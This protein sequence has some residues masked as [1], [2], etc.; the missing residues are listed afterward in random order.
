MHNAQKPTLDDLPSARQLWRS[1][2][3]AAAAAAAILVTVV[4]PS[5]YAIDP[6]GIGGVLGLTEMGEIKAQLAEEA[7]A[8]RLMMEGSSEPQSSVQPGIL[9]A[10]FGV[11]VGTAHAQEAPAATPAWREEITFTLTPG[12]GIEIKLVMS[13]GA[14][15]P[16]EW[17]VEGGAVNFDLHGDGSGNNI[18]YEKGRAVAEDSGELTAAFTGNHGWFWRNRGDA[19]VSVTL[20]V[21]GDYS[22]IKRFD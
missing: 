10:I 18:S 13:E 22:E 5:E 9:D 14:I 1:T 6:T 20:R 2:A 8:D 7:E 12:Q 17:V 11:I 21:G 19:S 4:W 16:F 15:A 3:I